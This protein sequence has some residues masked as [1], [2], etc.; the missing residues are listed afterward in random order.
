MTRFVLDNS[1]VMRW[2]TPSSKQ[3]DWDYAERVLESMKEAEA[4]VPGLLYLE[5]SNVLICAERRDE[6]TIAQTEDFV[7]RLRDM[8]IKVDSSTWE[9]SFSRIMTLARA[10]GLSS[11]DA[12]YLELAMRESLMLASLDK[13]LVKAAAKAGVGIYLREKGA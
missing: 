6:V 8:P 10:Y 1:V 9:Q 11:Y 7:S 4:V 5:A 12:A 2:F 3:S 13:M